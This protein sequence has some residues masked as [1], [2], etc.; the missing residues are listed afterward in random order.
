MLVLKRA[1]GK[2]KAKEEG[3]GGGAGVWNLQADWPK[4]HFRDHNWLS[5]PL[6]ST[7]K[8]HF[9]GLKQGKQVRQRL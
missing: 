5:H 6:R 1:K 7:P 3:G 9:D 8:E 4:E 2:K